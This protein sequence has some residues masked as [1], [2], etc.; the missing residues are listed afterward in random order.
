M[1]II[2]DVHFAGLQLFD[3]RT[4]HVL[5]HQQLNRWVGWGCA[6]IFGKYFFPFGDVVYIGLLWSIYCGTNTW[7]IWLNIKWNNCPLWACW[8]KA[9]NTIPKTRWFYMK[10]STTSI[11]RKP[12]WMDKHVPTIMDRNHHLHH[13]KSYCFLLKVNLSLNFLLNL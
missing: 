2:S 1:E 12:R 9:E 4:S 5:C 8:N 7:N 11:A 13:H 3:I 10:M 6:M